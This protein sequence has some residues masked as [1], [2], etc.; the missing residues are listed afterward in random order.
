[1]TLTESGTS[2]WYARRALLRAAVFETRDHASTGRT[3]PPRAAPWLTGVHRGGTA[4]TPSCSTAVDGTELLA[5]SPEHRH[6]ARGA[7]GAV[8]AARRAIRS[9]SGTGS[10]GAATRASA[11]PRRAH[12]GQDRPGRRHD[13][14]GATDGS[15]WSTPGATAGSREHVVIAT[16]SLR[17]VQVRFPRLT[18]GYLIDV[19]GTRH[20][21]ATCSRWRPPPRSRRTAPATRPAAA[22]QRSRCPAD[23]R[24]GGLARA[25]RRAADLL[26]LG[27]PALDPE[28]T[29]TG[30]PTAAPGCARLP[31]LSLGSAVRVRNECADRA[32][33]LPV[34]SDGAMARQFCDR[35]VQCGTSP[36]GTGRRPDHGRLRRARRQPGRRL[37]QRDDDPGGLTV[38][39]LVRYGSACECSQHADRRAR[40]ADPAARRAAHRRLRG[41]GVARA[42]RA[43]ARRTASGRPRCS[44]SGCAA[45]PRSALCATEF[46]LGAG[47]LLTAGRAGAGTP[48][49]RRPRGDRAA[50]LHGGGRAA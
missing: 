45:R 19:I 32:A 15:S 20:G 48:G 7:R 23:Q 41:Q 38:A 43:V 30:P 24:I 28:T 36:K 34:T 14:R 26:G 12:L 50:V 27:Y 42:R 49:A 9:S 39:A 6:L 46:A 37:L 2:A 10:L 3:G 16:A 8:R 11:A 13:R 40:G 31:Y 25:G 35:C 5:V 29:A 44:R 47:L 1:M 4:T 21:A 22:G 18:P 17:Q 33:V